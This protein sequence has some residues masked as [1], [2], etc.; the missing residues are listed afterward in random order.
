MTIKVECPCGQRYAFDVISREQ[1]PAAVA[2][3]SCGADGTS[4]ANDTFARQGIARSETTVATAGLRVAKVSPSEPRAQNPAA[5]FRRTTNEEDAWK[6]LEAK[7]D[8]R[9][10]AKVGFVVATGTFL[11]VI[12]SLFGVSFLG[13]NVWGIFDVVIIAGL[14]YG[15]FRFSRTCALLMLVVYVAGTFA[16]MAGHWSVTAII[17]RAVFVYYFARGAQA[18]F[19]YHSLKQIVD[20]ACS[21]TPEERAPN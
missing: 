2:C 19:T 11:L 3:P 8:V 10:A 14:A 7:A 4:A 21:R 20:F 17:V 18:A 12:L 1:M 5:V 13:V 9:R 6:L 16:I 15:T